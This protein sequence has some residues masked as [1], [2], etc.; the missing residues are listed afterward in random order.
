MNVCPKHDI[1]LKIIDGIWQCSRCIAYKRKKIQFD[2]MR[3]ERL[4]KKTGL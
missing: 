1:H 4:L 3:A 2:I